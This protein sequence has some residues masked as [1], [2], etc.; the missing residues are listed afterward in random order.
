MHEITDEPPEDEVMQE[1]RSIRK[2]MLAKYD[3]DGRRMMEDLQRRQYLSGR[4]LYGRSKVTGR[5]ELVF[6]GTG[7]P[8]HAPLDGTN[9]LP[10]CPAG[11]KPP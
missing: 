10:E 5:I 6:K 2:N 8:K 3:G 7:Q 1:L 9:S 11:P 4:D